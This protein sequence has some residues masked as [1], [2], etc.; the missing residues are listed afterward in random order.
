MLEHVTGWFK[1]TQYNYKRGISIV[2]LDETKWLTRYPG[3]ME[4]T[5]DQD[6]KFIGHEFIK[7]LIETEYRRTAKPSTSGST[8]SDEILERIF[9]VLGNP[10]Q[11]FNIREIYVDKR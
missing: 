8:T 3:P 7:P 5:Y 9:Q 6:S 10:V 2:N 11:T 4:I 1:I